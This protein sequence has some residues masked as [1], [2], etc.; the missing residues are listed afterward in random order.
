MPRKHC[1]RHLYSRL[2][3]WVT[4]ATIPVVP[5]H[6]HGHFGPRVGI[7]GGSV[8]I[9]DDTEGVFR[10]LG[11][12]HGLWDKVAES[13]DREEG[14]DREVEVYDEDSDSGDGGERGRRGGGREEGGK[15]WGGEG[16]Y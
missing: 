10:V 9:E 6:H 15:A 13:F 11:R 14:G 3:I 8:R 2:F 5:A 4:A 1:G 16:G 7:G 12:G